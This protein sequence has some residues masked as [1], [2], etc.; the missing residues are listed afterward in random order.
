MRVPHFVGL[1]ALQVLPLAALLLGWL[2]ARGV[3]QVSVRRQRQV[4]ALVSA[5]DAGLFVTLLVQAQ[6]GQSIVAPDQVTGVMV[7]VLVAAPA[8]AALLL[9][10]SRPGVIPDQASRV[11]AHSSR[12]D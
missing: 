5:A 10:L 8:A 4:V 11:P 3:L 6:R 2:V 1:H 7:A 12:D 9:A